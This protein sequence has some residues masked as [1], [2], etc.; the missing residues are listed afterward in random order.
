MEVWILYGDDIESTA[1]LAHEVRRFLSEGDRLGIKVQVYKPEDFDLL[2]TDEIR[3]TIMIRGEAVPLPDVV[4]PY[5]NHNDQ[6]YFPLAVVRQLERM[7]VIV[8]NT[9]ATIEMVRDKLHAHQV[10]AEAGLPSPATMLAK[11]PVDIELIEKTL[12]FPLIVKT[13]N[14]ALGIGVFLIQNEKAF[15]DLI[16]LIGETNPNLQ[17]IFQKFVAASSGRDLRLFTLED[18]VIAAME[19]RAADGDFKANFSSGGSVHA[20]EPDEAAVNIALETVKALNIQIGGVDLLFTD[21]GGYTI[22]EANTFPGFKGLE[23]ASGVNVP[24]KIFESMERKVAERRKEKQI[25][26][27]KQ[28]K[29]SEAAQPVN[30]NESSDGSHML[31]AE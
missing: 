25:E 31:S 6:G 15:K 9:A 29:E 26:I 16:D 30:T 14:G 2:V 4:Y 18:E 13:L 24:E 22:C 12:G 11:F 10:I 17:L 8:Y 1:D 5:L 23:R 20:Y 21:D 28:I 27:S 3:D 7:G 19:R